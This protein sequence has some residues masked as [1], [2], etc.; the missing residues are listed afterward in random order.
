MVVP[1]GPGGV[2]HDYVPFYFCRLSSMLLAVVRSKNVDQQYLIYF[3]VPITVL[4][5]PDVVFTNAS[6]N[7]IEPPDFFTDPTDLQTLD[8]DLIDSCKW[9]F[10]EA[11]K[12]ARMAEA[13]IHQRVDIADVDHIIIWNKSVKKEVESIFQEEGCAN[14]PLNF[15][16]PYPKFHYFTQFFNN[17]GKSLVAGPRL[18]KSACDDAIEYI[19]ETGQSSSAQFRNIRELLAGLQDDFGCLPET[20]ELIGLESE[21][22]IHTEDV[23]THT[24]TVVEKLLESAEFNSLNGADQRLVEIAAYLHDIGK[25]PK[26]RWADNGGKQQVDDDHPIRSVEMLQRILTEEVA[27]I[28]PRSVQVLAK[29]VC[30]HD[31]VGDILGKGRDPKQL[32]EI[33]ETERELDMLIALGL[34]DMRAVNSMWDMLH[35]GKIPALRQRVV[36]HINAQEDEDE[37]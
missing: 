2:V 29:L 7:T 17:S 3:A 36:D 10:P 35:R 20:A 9:K 22:D 28:R 31:L 18:I 24:L 26:A 4:D 11:Q 12:Q 19:A 14:P 1:C 30:Y 5:R 27:T 33:A 16:G 32:E 21:N 23:G 13:L 8:W 34:A 37:E 6:A 15:H 25:G